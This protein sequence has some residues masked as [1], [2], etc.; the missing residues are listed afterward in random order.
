MLISKG[1]RDCFFFWRSLLLVLASMRGE[2]GTR[3]EDLG[4]IESAK[5][6]MFILVSFIKAIADYSLCFYWAGRRIWCN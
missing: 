1:C 5:G 3:K 2:G 6:E 4:E